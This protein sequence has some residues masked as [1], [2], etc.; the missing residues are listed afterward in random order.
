MSGEDAPRSYNLVLE[1]KTNKQRTD[2]VPRIKRPDQI[3][4]CDL[5]DRHRHPRLNLS[6]LVAVNHPHPVQHRRV[7]SSV[8]TRITPPVGDNQSNQRNL[9]A[10]RTTTFEALVVRVDGCSGG[11]GVLTSV[12]G[13]IV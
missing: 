13:C 7:R 5:S 11:R 1:I 3:P 8:G 12:P 10:D 2:R 9:R 6:P 4:C